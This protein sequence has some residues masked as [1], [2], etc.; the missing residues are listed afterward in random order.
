MC[1]LTQWDCLLENFIKFSCRP[2]PRGSLSAALGAVAP[3]RSGPSLKPLAEPD[4]LASNQ[5]DYEEG[6]VRPVAWGNLFNYL[7][8]PIFGPRRCLSPPE[9]G[10]RPASSSSAFDIWKWIEFGHSR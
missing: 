7:R 6:L 5:A 2:P 3:A 9:P 10:G 8:A 4:D 1:P